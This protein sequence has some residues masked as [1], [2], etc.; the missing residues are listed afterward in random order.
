MEKN[1]R[2]G[3]TGLAVP[4]MPARLMDASESPPWVN[5]SYWQARYQAIAA[6]M[7]ADPSAIAKGK[8]GNKRKR[9]IDDG[10]CGR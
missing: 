10:L 4:P 3:V 8:K 9:E 1:R 2:K 6:I 7:H 5:L